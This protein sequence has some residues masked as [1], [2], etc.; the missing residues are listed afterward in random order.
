MSKKHFV[1]LAAA[2]ASIA[3]TAERKRTAHLIA[4]VCKRLNGRFK[5]VRFLTACKVA[6]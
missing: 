4:E 3:N 2:I 1:A 6:P 5:P